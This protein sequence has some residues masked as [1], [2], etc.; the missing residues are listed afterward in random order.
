MRLSDNFIDPEAYSFNFSHIPE[1]ILYLLSVEEAEKPLIT[2][3]KGILKKRYDKVVL[4][5]LDGFGWRLYKE[6]K[7]KN[8]LLRRISKEGD[9][10]RLI[11]QFPST[12]SCN[13]TTIH[14]GMDVSSHGLYEWVYFEP[15]IGTLIYPL[16]FSYARGPK[17][18]ET[19]K[20]NEKGIRGKDILPA[21][22]F[23]KKLNNAGVKPFVFQHKEYTPSTYSDIMLNGSCVNIFRTLPEAMSTLAGMVNSCNEKAYYFLYYD[24]FDTISHEYGPGSTQLES[25]ME[26][27]FLTLEKI[28]LDSIT[29]DAGNVLFL[30]TADHGQS[31]IDLEKKVYINLEMPELERYIKRDDKGDPLAPAGSCRD[32]FLYVKDDNVDET[33]AILQNKLNGKA[34]A[35]KTTDLIK[36]GYFK[37]ILSDELKERLGNIAVLPF[38][39][40]SVWW[41]EKGIFEIRSKGHHGGLSEYEM[42]IPLIVWKKN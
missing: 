19:L 30:I 32:L 21:G 41:Y 27:F 33:V 4:F 38:E 17:E 6:F 18:R 37:E 13:L 29:K 15:K 24:G 28:F 36:Y 34:I 35:I 31:R 14:T 11:S 40:Y 10:I 16:L 3:K 25:E 12:T 23:Y 2:D 20:D 8:R 1:L 42:E 22:G 39:G 9:E 5:L 7:K 26:I